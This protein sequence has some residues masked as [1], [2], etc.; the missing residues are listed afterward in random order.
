[1][2]GGPHRSAPQANLDRTRPI[3]YQPPLGVATCVV[4][5]RP[6]SVGAGPPSPVSNSDLPRVYQPQLSTV[7]TSVVSNSPPPLQ[8]Y[9][10]PPKA[11]EPSRQD[12]EYSFDSPRTE[13]LNSEEED[14]EDIP[15]Y[16]RPRVPSP[17]SPGYFR[18]PVT[19]QLY[20]RETYQ[21][22]GE[23]SACEVRTFEINSTPSPDNSPIHTFHPGRFTPVNNF[24]DFENYKKSRQKASPPT[25][26]KSTATSPHEPELGR[27][28]YPIERDIRK[29]RP[30]DT[31][32]TIATAPN[33]VA[34]LQERNDLAQ[35]NDRLSHYITEVKHLREQ[36]HRVD[37]TAF[38]ESIKILEDGLYNLKNMY[39]HELDKAR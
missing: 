30:P 20:T 1:M 31:M 18:D 22:D 25:S 9:H 29:D 24:A 23:V 3:L 26:S 37:S 2:D 12:S 38:L 34:R 36:A 17:L 32:A 11:L 21:P 5:P 28:S 4:S 6:G 14:D 7:Q 39:E 8:Y 10:R 16:Y 13:Q 33:A 35:L 15:P 19:R 27:R